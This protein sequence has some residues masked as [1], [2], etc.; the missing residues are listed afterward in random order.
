M[1]Q[2]VKHRCGYL[3][4]FLAMMIT[5]ACS[6]SNEIYVSANNGSTS[7][8]GTKKDPFTTIS[9]AIS[10][11]EEG[12][13]IHVL[14]G[15]YREKL[16]ITTSGISITAGKNVYITGTDMVNI[17]EDSGNGLY[18]MY[19]PGKV[20]QLFVDGVPQVRA[21][22][23]NQKVDPD[24][25]NFTAINVKVSGD[26][27]ISDELPVVDGFFNGASVWMILWKRWVGGTARIKKQEGKMLILDSISCPYRGEGIAFISNCKNCLDNDGEWY[28]DNDTLY[29]LNSTLKILNSNIEVKT[30]E[31][32]IEL[33]GVRDVKITGVNGYA[34]NIIFR[35][36]KGCKVS[37]GN[38]KW[39]NDY[40]FI[41]AKTSYSRGRK[42]SLS[43]YGLGIAMFGTG[44]TLSCCEVSWAA[45]DCVSLYG[46]DNVIIDCMVHEGNYLGTD[47]APVSL[48]GYGNK[49]LYSEI[50]NGGRDVISAPSAQAFEVMHDK[51]HHTGLVAWDVGLI[52][53]YDTDGKNAEIAY[54]IFHDANSGNPEAWWGASGIYLD[55]NSRNFLVHHN[56]SY[57]AKGRGILVNDPGRNIR[58]Y[59]N[60]VFNTTS[61]M[62]PYN[63]G[64]FPGIKGADCKFYNNYFDRPVKKTEW[65]EE[66]N[67]IYTSDD[68]LQDREHGNYLPKKGSKLIDA[69]TVVEELKDIPFI[70]KAPD[71]GAFEYEIPAWAAGPRCILNKSKY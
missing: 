16:N 18:K 37:N 4:F 50:F 35:D 6:S 65:I 2:P 71:V 70:G 69:G 47:A 28:W 62:I 32:L 27:L 39:L 54:N 59:N 36:T 43:M 8:K 3:L 52:Y 40:D 17:V 21:K 53:T 9:H 19:V 49:I 25:F 20:T 13:V 11:A 48:G 41:N 22:Y 51:I 64:H 15:V 68:L 33:N 5:S 7:G 38:F 66:K 23:P 29:Y 67:N 14:D 12:D 58:V 45:G 56:V 1:K 42:A 26:T 46:A 61:V 44:D 57:N 55:N 34:G 60:I 24:L 31:S 30:R 10:L 63:N